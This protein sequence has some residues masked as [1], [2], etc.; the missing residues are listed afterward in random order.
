LEL[1]AQLED[2][3]QCRAHVNFLRARPGDVKHSQADVARAQEVLGF[4]T[5]VNVQQ[6]LAHTLAYYR[7]QSDSPS[8]ST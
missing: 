5:Q 8:V 2:L 6:G 3:S 1:I 4:E 7:Q